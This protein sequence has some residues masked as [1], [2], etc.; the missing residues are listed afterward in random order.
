MRQLFTF[1]LF[2]FTKLLFSQTIPNTIWLSSQLAVDSFPIKYPSVHFISTLVIGID[3]T[4]NLTDITSLSPLS[5]LKRVNNLFISNNGLLSSLNGL[6]SIDTT[7]PVTIYH[8]PGL[9]TL[10][11]LHHLRKTDILII[12]RNDALT[13]LQGL[14]SLQRAYSMAIESCANLKNLS[15]L[16]SLRYTFAGITVLDNK[17]LETLSG[18]LQIP[19]ARLVVARN[20]SLLHF[21]YFPKMTNLSLDVYENKNLI[22]FGDFGNHVPDTIGML[23]RNNPKLSNLDALS[24]VRRLGIGLVDNDALINVVGFDSTTQLSANIAGPNIQQIKFL[25]VKEIDGFTIH[26]CPR[27]KQLHN[28]L[29]QSDTTRTQIQIY[30]NDSLQTIH[31]DYGPT[32]LHSIKIYDNPQLQSVTGFNGIQRSWALTSPT[33]IDCS[34]QEC[35]I[36][37]KAPALNSI[38]GFNQLKNGRILLNIGTTS[39]QVERTEGF[40]APDAIFETISVFPNLKTISAFN[41]ARQ[42]DKDI[43]IAQVHDT[44][45]VFHHLQQIGIDQTSLTTQLDIRTVQGCHHDSFCFGHLKTMHRSFLSNGFQGGQLI[46]FPALETIENAGVSTAYN[47][48]ISGSFEGV[49]PKLQKTSAF[50]L[51]K[52]PRIKSL[53]GI[54]GITTFAPSPLITSHIYAADC[55]SLADC[56]PI[57]H[58]LNNATFLPPYLPQL[59]LNN[60]LYPC[61]SPADVEIYCDTVTSGIRPEPNPA[62]P[63]RLWPNPIQAGSTIHIELGEDAETATYALRVTDHNGRVALTGQIYF[64]D[65]RAILPISMLPAG[66]YWLHLNTPKGPIH[67]AAFVKSEH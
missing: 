34:Y 33:Q 29:P 43:Y 50:S 37:I 59:N 48:D 44:L 19:K 49:Y 55:D 30:N 66:H 23:A 26:D 13:N 14:N 22:D 40:N 2:L 64:T 47:N 7:G 53:K 54:E 32:Y 5:G 6:E 38:S 39:H 15:G 58:I 67:S 10:N 65:G 62:T 56:S 41:H 11:G 35:G 42:V 28:F 16:D 20:D 45:S 8:N 63:M 46:R 3:D 52:C 9:Q 51:G 1:C 24:A 12:R 21:G 36:F 18:M 60:P 31:L 61:T 4:I 17:R 27:L 57:C 25:S